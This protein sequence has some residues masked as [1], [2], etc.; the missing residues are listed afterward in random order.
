MEFSFQKNRPATVAVIVI[1]A[2]ALILIGALLPSVIGSGA[3][4]QSNVAIAGV[5]SSTA[6]KDASQCVPKVNQVLAALMQNEEPSSSIYGE[7]IIFDA[8]NL[9][10]MTAD[11]TGGYRLEYTMLVTYETKQPYTATFRGNMA[12]DMATR[13]WVVNGQH[14]KANSPVSAT[15]T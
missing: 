2:G 8:E 13:S 9:T 14:L 11:G 12:Y 3:K 6:T 5:N 1:A 15:C 7:K 10:S 4:H